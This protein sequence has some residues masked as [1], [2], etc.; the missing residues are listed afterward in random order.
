MSESAVPRDV[1]AGRIR[2][3][4]ARQMP[5]GFDMAAFGDDLPLGP[6]GIGLDSVALVE[7]VLAC[8]KDFAIRLPAEIL[9]ASLLTIAAL[10]DAIEQSLRRPQR[11]SAV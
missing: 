6:A 11:G 2:A 7:L 3:L 5:S 4:A 1:I 8:E 9:E 10:T